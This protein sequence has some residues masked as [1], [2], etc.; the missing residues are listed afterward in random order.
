FKA[1]S[2]IRMVPALTDGLPDIFDIDAEAASLLEFVAG[3]SQDRAVPFIFHARQTE[4]DFEL[5]RHGFK[6]FFEEWQ[7][8][9]A[10]SVRVNS[11]PG[12]VHVFVAGLLIGVE[13]NRARLIGKTEFRLN[14][15]G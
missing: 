7:R 14:P 1:P 10:H 11:G 2:I 12:D 15:V 6:A 9:S 4:L 13:A 3:G 5:A 8:H